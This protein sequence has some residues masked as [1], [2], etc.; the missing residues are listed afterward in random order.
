M[1]TPESS[2]VRD[3]LGTFCYITSHPEM[4]EFKITIFACWFVPDSVDQKW[5]PDLAGVA[6]SCFTWCHLGTLA[7]TPGMAGKAGPPSPHGLSSSRRPT[8][9]SSCG[10]WVPIGWGW[11]L[12]GH[13]RP[14]LKVPN[15]YLSHIL[16]VRTSHQ[17]GL[18]SSCGEADSISWWEKL[19]RICGHFQSTTA[20]TPKFI[21]L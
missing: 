20:E 10:C 6:C 9:V 5:E 19:Q 14:R 7:G 8:Q 15:C 18:N 21:I 16:L 2:L 1:D 12:W 11:T 3:V 4:Q 17:T 13:L